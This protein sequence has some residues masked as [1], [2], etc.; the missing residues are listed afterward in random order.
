MR[1]LLSLDQGTTSSRAF[2]VDEDG[3]IVTR[4]QRPLAC[5][6][7][8]PGWVEQNPMEIWSTQIAAARE[9]LRELQHADAMRKASFANSSFNLQ[10]KS[11]KLIAGL[12][13]ANQRETTIVWE[14]ATGLPVYNAIVW[15][16]R[17]TVGLC[18]A[19]RERGLVEQIRAKTG[20]MID[21]YFSATKLAWILDNVPKARARAELGELCFGTVDSWLVFRLTNGKHHVTDGSNASR[22]M[23]YNIHSQKWDEEL[24]AWLNIPP[25]MLPRIVSSA[26]IAA[27]CDLEHFGFEI[28]IAAL[29]G[30]QQ[31]AC[32]GQ[33]C[34]EPGSAKNTYGTGSFLLMN[35]GGAAVSPKKQ[36][37]FNC[38]LEHR[39]H[40][41]ASDLLS[42]RFGV[43]VG[44]HRAVVARQ[45]WHHQRI[46]RH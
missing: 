14:R 19:L 2:T 22:T 17:R 10:T 16:D 34:I 25:S 46:C 44:R 37:G 36:S 15:Q 6:Y 28:P 20:L 8:Q 12:G 42:R 39:R 9:A 18:D 26:G 43:H 29:V 32:Y 38:G 31:A 30:D 3:Q 33:M 24:L 41:P 13:I 23:L 7:P 5:S 21:P 11:K 40:A 1:Y 45:P 27:H 35:T 4:A